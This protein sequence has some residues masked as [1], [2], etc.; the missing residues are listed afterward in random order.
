MSRGLTLEGL[1]VSYFIR[2]QKC[3]MLFCKWEDGLDTEMAMKILQTI[4][5][6]FFDKDFEHISES[7]EELSEDIQYMQS[8]NRTPLEFALRI[9]ADAYD[10]KLKLLQE[11][12]WVQE[13]NVSDLSYS[14]N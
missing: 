6:F 11:A 13:K 9:R 2:I 3:M 10:K 8:K 7:V 4:F 12:K 5:T 14:V 1:I